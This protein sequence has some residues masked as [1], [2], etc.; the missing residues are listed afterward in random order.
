MENIRE[1]RA[2]STGDVDFPPAMQWARRPIGFSL[3]NMVTWGFGL[4][5]GILV[6]VGFFWAGWRL[7]SRWNR[8]DAEWYSHA[9]IWVWTAL[10]FAWQS[11]QLN[12]TMRY[13][14]PIYPT[15]T[16]LGAWGLFAL[17][18]CGNRRI[19]DGDAAASAS[20]K[21]LGWLKVGAGAAAGPGLLPSAG[22]TFP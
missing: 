22:H 12:P 7:L 14:L 21:S 6:W 2:Q 11:I 1:Q 17:F 16:I 10:Y 13:Q 9:L 15:L 3:Q 18:D 19:K 4:P 8:R 5:L 20:E